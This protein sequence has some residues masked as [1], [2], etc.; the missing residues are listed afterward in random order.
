MQPDTRLEMLQHS[1][2]ERSWSFCSSVS[3]RGYGLFW[4]YEHDLNSDNNSFSESSGYSESL[5]GI[6]LCQSVFTR[7][8]RET[9]VNQKQEGAWQ[10]EN[11][12][13]IILDIL[14]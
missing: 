8:A 2:Q 13:L 1:Q 3:S 7:S 12:P 4:G 9:P 6:C 5:L 14:L 10:E 11:K